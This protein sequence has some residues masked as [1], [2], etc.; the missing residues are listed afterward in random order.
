MNVS[1]TRFSSCYDHTM[2]ALVLAKNLTNVEK[3]QIGQASQ[4]FRTF[5]GRT[6]LGLIA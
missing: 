6:S 3:C 5:K 1:L 4:R 2:I